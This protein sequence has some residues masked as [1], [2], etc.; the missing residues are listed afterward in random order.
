MYPFRDTWYLEGRATV[1]PWNNNKRNNKNDKLSSS[2]TTW[3]G[4]KVSFYHFKHPSV[5]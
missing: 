1:Q 5:S 3:C 4:F 2:F